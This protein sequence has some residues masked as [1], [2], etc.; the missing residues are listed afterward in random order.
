MTRLLLVLACL[1][2]PSLAHAQEL[3]DRSPRVAANL[4]LGVAGELDSYLN[5]IHGEVDM[6]ASVGFDLRGELPV[7]DFLVI[8]ALFEFLSSE[9]DASGAEREEGFSFDGFARL[10]WVFEAIERTLFVEPYLALLRAEG[11]SIVPGGPRVLVGA[12]AYD[13]S[14][15]PPRR[16]PD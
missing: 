9:Q 7:L 14:R 11:A 2:A 5:D 12:A 15:A 10:R 4:A 16:V 8:G 3:D 6:D 1:L 13:L